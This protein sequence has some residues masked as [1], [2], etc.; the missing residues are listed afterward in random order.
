MALP[1][2]YP[3]DQ[4]RSLYRQRKEIENQIYELTGGTLA[5]EDDNGVLII[6]HNITKIPQPL[7]IDRQWGPGKINISHTE[8]GIKMYTIL[9]TEE[10]EDYCSTNDLCPY[11][12][13]ENEETDAGKHCPNNCWG[14]CK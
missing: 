9:T 14:E 7:T 12:G 1:K 3:I 2:E 4:I 11:C 8:N 10:W 6:A 5:Y 13:T